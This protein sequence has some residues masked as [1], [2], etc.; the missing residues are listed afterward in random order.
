[1]LH[2]LLFSAASRSRTNPPQ[3]YNFYVVNDGIDKQTSLLRSPHN[4]RRRISAALNS[5]QEGRLRN[6]QTSVSQAESGSNVLKGSATRKDPD[7]M[8]IAELELSMSALR[9]V[10]VSVARSRGKVGS[11]S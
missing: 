4:H 11:K 8:E 1:M 5:P 10:P 7:D 6:R 9:F 3:T 2:K